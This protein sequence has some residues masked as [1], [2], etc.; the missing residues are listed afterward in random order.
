MEENV[1]WFVEIIAGSAVAFLGML[2]TVTWRFS[3]RLQGMDKARQDGDDALHT[4][5][6]E[7]K[8]DAVEKTDFRELSSSLRKDIQSMEQQQI[9]MNDATNQRLDALLAAIA[10]RNLHR[11]KDDDL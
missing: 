6:N 4:R 3:R 8:H 9:R 2:A 5:V 1:K 11:Q 7:V 10:N